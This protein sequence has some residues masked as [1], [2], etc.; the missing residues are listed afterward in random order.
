MLWCKYKPNN[1]DNFIIN[2][3]LIMKLKRYVKYLKNNENMLNIAFIGISNSC[4]L[5]LCRCFL[6][7]IFGN[8]IYKLHEDEFITKQNCTHYTIK[9]LYSKYHYEISFCGLQYADK[10]VLIDI[11][12]KYFSTYNVDTLKYK[13]LVI[14]DFDILTKPAQYA[15]RRKIEQSNLFVRFIFLIKSSS[16]IESSILSRVMV[17]RC[18][19]PYKSEIY[20]YIN[21]IILTEKLTINN[22]ELS[23]IVDNSLNNIGN[24]LY[25]L[26]L[27]ISKQKIDI[28][29]PEQI[30]INELLIL[31]D[32]SNILI[33]EIRAVLDKI[34]LSKLDKNEIFKKLLIKGISFIESNNYKLIDDFISEVAKQQNI[35][36]ISNK[37][38]IC[39][40]TVIYYI[41]LYIKI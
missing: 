28:Y 12:N 34:L 15:L 41:F 25:Y 4:K 9:L 17:L 23:T 8:D 20:N 32:K 39:I 18:R 40:E 7:S 27:L 33:K 29:I 36:Q 10:G 31:I 2:P 37:F 38:T 14:K 1:L 30:I 3:Q 19:K 21:N 24:S 16:K 5:T 22:K 11:L 13:I 6:A 26:E 35:Y